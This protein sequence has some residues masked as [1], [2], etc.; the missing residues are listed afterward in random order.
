MIP[1]PRARLRRWCF[2]LAAFACVIVALWL[3]RAPLLRRAASAWIVDQPIEPAGAVAL[4]GGG[5]PTP[6]Y[7][8]AE[9]YRRGVARKIVLVNGRLR[10]T[11]RLGITEPEVEW[12]KHKLVERGV[13]ESDI[14]IVGN[15]A[16]DAFEAMKAL[17]DWA[18]QSHAAR[19]ILPTE[20]FDTRRLRW[21]ARHAA[22][23]LNVRVRAVGDPEYSPANWW[24]HE[25]G[26]I[27]FENEVVLWIYY[28]LKF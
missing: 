12:R 20:Q 28:K 13:S 27:A 19:I 10:P 23:G 15:E 22:P 18:K 9:L 16:P 17:D 21:C 2:A 4:I 6:V 7:E 14:V 1:R 8:A 5:M 11:D 25:R 26:L 3:F 24:Q